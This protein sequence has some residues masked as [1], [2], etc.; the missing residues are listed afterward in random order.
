M[1]IIGDDVE[2]VLIA[3]GREVWSITGIKAST[4][5][6]G[7]VACDDYQ[8]PIGE[9]YAAEGSTVACPACGEE[10]PESAY[11]DAYRCSLCDELIAGDRDTFLW[12]AQQY[13]APTVN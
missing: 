10:V 1:V 4:A 7:N 6:C 9:F 8:Q 11:V 12:H 3:E 5:L 13:H 2:A